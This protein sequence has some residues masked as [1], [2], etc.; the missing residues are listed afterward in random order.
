MPRD[1]T[2]EK[3]TGNAL[4]PS[5]DMALPELMLTEIYVAIWRH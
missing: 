1:L 2:S 3:S 5:D 4:L